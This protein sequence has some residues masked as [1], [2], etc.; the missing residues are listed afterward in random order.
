LRRLSDG[1]AAEQSGRRVPSFVAP[2]SGAGARSD[3][4]PGDRQIRAHRHDLPVTT[5]TTR[6]DRAT[7]NARRLITDAIRE[8]ESSRVALGLSYAAVARSVGMSQSQVR[9]VVHGETDDVGIHQMCRLHAAVGLE[10]LI[11][12]TPVGDPLRDAGQVRLLHRFHERLPS[13]I[14]WHPERPLA[15]WRDARAWDSV[16]D[17]HGCVDGV[18]GVTRFGDAQAIERRAMRK[19]RDDATVQHLILLIADT[20]SNRR[21][22]ELVRPSLRSDL[23][24]DTR[25]VM[26]ALGRGRCPGASGVVV[27]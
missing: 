8:F 14:G 12:T 27:L 20:R 17:G 10:S 7:A 23:P 2:A 1:S 21:T 4:M 18:E 26:W 15:G 22:L 3:G 11:R 16:I 6:L 25:D 9:R 19:L 5:R 24:L 13:G